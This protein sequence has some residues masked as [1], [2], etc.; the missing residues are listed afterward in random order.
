MK[1]AGKPG[2]GGH[3][4]DYKVGKKAFPAFTMISRPPGLKKM[5]IPGPGTY[6]SKSPE[7]NRGPTYAFGTATQREPTK[8]TC[9]PGPGGYSV[10]S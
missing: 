9:A 6:E 7:K 4:P 10:P 8:Q 5:E 2:P 1:S 3:D